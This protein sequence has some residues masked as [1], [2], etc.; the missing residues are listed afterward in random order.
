MT[1][2]ETRPASSP[3]ARRVTRPA[4]SRPLLP[5]LLRSEWTKLRTVRS[6][7]WTLLVMALAM[8]G[9]GA[10]FTARYRIEPVSA[11]DRAAFDPTA[12]S[13]SGL[14]LAQLA[15]AVLGAMAIT[16][17]YATGSIRATFT[18]APSRWMVLTAKVV[19][20]GAVTASVGTIASFIT[21][22][23]GQ[24]ILATKGLEAHIGDPGV[25]RA[26]IGAGLYLAVVGLLALG[27]GALIRRTAGAIA[28][29]VTLM[30]ILTG[31]VAALPTTWQN[32]ITGYLPSNAG[33]AIVGHTRFAARA[34]LLLP[35]GVGFAI[36]CGYAAAALIA[37]AV[38]L[39]RRD[40]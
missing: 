26:I 3:A 23:V 27:F 22:V 16:S 6:T 13:L 24:H 36:F 31:L 4:A 37:A 34:A 32:A 10:L 14:F 38:V 35:P 19:V 29:V 11:A 18:A 39:S 2:A 5:D 17:E 33:Q 12:Y 25:V 40:T 8:V 28:V 15:A 1:S 20:L 7:Y 9:L 30:F 21:F